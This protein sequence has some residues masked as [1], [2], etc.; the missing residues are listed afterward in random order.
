MTQACC[1]SHSVQHLCGALPR[2]YNLHTSDQQ[3]HGNVF[4][5]GKFWQQMMEL[6]DKAQGTITQASPLCLIQT[7]HI[8][9]VDQYRTRG[10]S[11]K[12]PEAVQQRA[13]ARSRGADNRYAL[14]RPD[15]EI[16]P[17]EHINSQLSIRKGADQ[18]T[19]LEHGLL[20]HSAGPLP[21]GSAPPARPDRAW[22]VW[23]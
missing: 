11:I 16:H 17:F 2:R 19:A 1:Q 12:P 23:S 14:T 10:H 4:Q 22:P 8:G 9:A 21:D 3:G 15:T 7:H 20:T 18:G 5:G 6:I 13:L